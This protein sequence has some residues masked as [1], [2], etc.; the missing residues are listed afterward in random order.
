LALALQG[1]SDVGRV[2]S[3]SVIE[4]EDLKARCKALDL[5][6]VVLRPILL[7]C[8]MQQLSQNDS[9][10]AEAVGLQIEPLANF[11]WPIPKHANAEVG[12]EEIAQH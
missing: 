11:S 5:G 2:V 10:N 8:A 6:P 1:R 9:R 3:S 4:R 12:V 7:R